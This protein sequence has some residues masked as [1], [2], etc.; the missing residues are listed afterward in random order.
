MATLTMTTT[1][2]MIMIESNGD[3]DDYYYDTPVFF[4]SVDLYI[5][6]SLESYRFSCINLGFAIANFVLPIDLNEA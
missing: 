2:M 6:F 5:S 3:D 1:T 4:S